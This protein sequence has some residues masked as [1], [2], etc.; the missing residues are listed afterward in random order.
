MELQ[1]QVAIVTGASRGIGKGIAQTL[2]REGAIVVVN[3]LNDEDEANAVVHALLPGKAYAFQADVT[4]PMQVEGMVNE[5]VQKFGTIDIVVNNAGICPFMP[6]LDITPAVWEKTWATNVTGPFFVSQAA[7]RHM[8]SQKRGTI[9][10][11]ASVGVYVASPEQT[12]YAATKG[13]LFSLTRSMAV[14]LGP[15]GIRVNAILVGGVP[16]DINRDQYTSEYVDWLTHRLPLRVMGTPEDI[17]EAV[18]FLASS[19]SRWITG[20][21]LAVDGGRL[22]AP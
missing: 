22:V 3:Y 12:H 18:V 15:A 8:V 16:T 10:H 14:A 2:A 17:G 20:A 1:G 4:Q 13:A 19:R 6:F 5:V 21:S 11:I 9:I 7:A